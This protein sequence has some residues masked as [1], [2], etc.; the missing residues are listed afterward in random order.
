MN[1]QIFRGPGAAFRAPSGSGAVNSNVFGRQV[2][3]VQEIVV[4]SGV[5][6]LRCNK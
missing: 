3:P 1:F 4:F 2:A 6:W 5:K